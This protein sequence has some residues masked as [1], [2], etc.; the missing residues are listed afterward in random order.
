MMVLVEEGKERWGYAARIKAASKALLNGLA[1]KLNP[2]DPFPGLIEESIR[3]AEVRNQ[4]LI[5]GVI[6]Y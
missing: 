2:F 1:F 4:E 3:R 6:P 5:D